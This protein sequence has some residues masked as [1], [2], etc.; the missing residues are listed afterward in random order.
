MVN[1]CWYRE[2]LN[3][4][5]AVTSAMHFIASHLSFDFLSRG[6]HL[7][8]KRIYRAS[9]GS[10][11]KVL[12]FCI[13]THGAG[14][15]ASQEESI[16]TRLTPAVFEIAIGCKVSSGERTQR[17]VAGIFCL[18]SRYDLRKRCL[19]SSSTPDRKH[20][21]ALARSLAHTLA[22]WTCSRPWIFGSLHSLVSLATS[23]YPGLGMLELHDVG[24]LDLY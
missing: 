14:L 2:D 19:S 1:S 23:Q 20:T 15:C 9:C 18:Q 17:P 3:D 5:M 11:G 21:T 16:S 6:A 24:L 13:G 10:F 7:D 8:G 22:E 12:G 4:F